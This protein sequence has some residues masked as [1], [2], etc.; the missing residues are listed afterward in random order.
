MSITPV[1]AFSDLLNLMEEHPL[2]ALEPALRLT[3]DSDGILLG[4]LL[5]LEIIGGKAAF[6]LMNDTEEAALNLQMGKNEE[7][8]IHLRNT[9][10]AP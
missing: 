7:A 4:K 9:V 5:M 2:Q 6:Y 3:N 1:L 10:A 8:I